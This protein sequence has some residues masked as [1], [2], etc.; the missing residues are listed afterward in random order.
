MV[1]VLDLEK[2]DIIR[3]DNQFWKVIKSENSTFGRGRGH[4]KLSLKNLKTGNLVKKVFRPE[5]EV[6][7]AEVESKPAIFI[8]KDRKS[9]VFLINNKRLSIPLEEVGNKI[10]YLKESKPEQEVKII[11]I[12]NN[13][14]SVELPAKVDLRVI[15]SPP[16]IKG[17]TIASN[18][19]QVVLETGLKIKV[20]MFIKKGDL[21]RV[22]TE[23]GDYSERV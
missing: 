8:Y 19:K 15:D 7:E 16:S 13:P 12:N 2:G 14:Y 17:D 18:N 22:N 5:E 11:Y 6:K 3:L 23:T 1:K 20:P 10:F 4:I 9:A 21:V